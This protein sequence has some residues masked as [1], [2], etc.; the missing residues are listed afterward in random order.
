MADNYITTVTDRGDISISEDVIAGLVGAA[1]TEVDGVAGVSNTVG[2]DIL[3]LIGK[4]TLSKGVKVSKEDET[5]IVD[6]LI[7]V[8]YGCV[9]TEVAKNVQ[10]AVS[11]ALEAMSGI[12]PVVNVHVSGVS[13]RTP[14]DK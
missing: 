13:F 9:V 7:M 6:V 2:S 8:N 1:I 12:T 14:A 11:N 10:A 4:R 3:D 5:V